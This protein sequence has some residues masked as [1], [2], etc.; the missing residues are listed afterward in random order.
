MSKEA[1]VGGGFDWHAENGELLGRKREGAGGRPVPSALQYFRPMRPGETIRYE[2]F[3][4]PGETDVTPCLDEVA[5]FLKPA[6]VQLHWIVDQMF[7]DWSQP[8]PG[9]RRGESQRPKTKRASAQGRRLECRAL[10]TTAKTVKI[11]LNGVFIFESDIDPDL[12]RRFG[13]FYNQDQTAAR[14]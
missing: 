5:Y 10:E 1:N 6:G 2:F 12:G 3:Y 13:L 14:A 8:P 11:T 7:G 4:Q 9:Q